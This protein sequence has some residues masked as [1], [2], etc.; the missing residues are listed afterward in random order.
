MAPTFPLFSSRSAADCS[1]F[2]PLSSRR[3]LSQCLLYLPHHCRSPC[4]AS[5]TDGCNPDPYDPLR[6][7]DH[8]H[9]RLDGDNSLNRHSLGHYL[10]HSHG[11][12]LVRGPLSLPSLSLSYLA[13]VGSLRSRL[14][15][16]APSSEVPLQRRSFFVRRSWNRRP[17]ERLHF[18]TPC[19]RLGVQRVI[20]PE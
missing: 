18:R 10:A 17:D 3:S 19:I 8:R 14:V 15:V 12:D 11:L 2:L 7:Y 6:T 9:N 13:F 4:S 20:R 5:T 1:I 16:G